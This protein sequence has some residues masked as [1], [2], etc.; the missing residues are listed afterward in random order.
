MLVIYS[1]L[2]VFICYIWDLIKDF[3]VFD[4]FPVFSKVMTILTWDNVNSE[5]D[6]ENS[7]TTTDNST[8]TSNEV[9]FGKINL[10]LNTFI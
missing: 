5:G 9:A 10:F 2:F 4:S 6:K 7:T 3:T 8:S 1:A